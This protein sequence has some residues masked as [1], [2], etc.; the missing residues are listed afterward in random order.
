[1]LL[2]KTIEI[3]VT[4]KAIM[5]TTTKNVK[6]KIFLE[7][8]L[9][10]TFFAPWRLEAAVEMREY[11]VGDLFMT[12]FEGLRQSQH[13][14]R[15]RSAVVVLNADEVEDTYATI[16]PPQN[17]GTIIGNMA[18]FLDA[19]VMQAVLSRPLNVQWLE[20]FMGPKAM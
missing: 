9:H 20:Q 6:N 7:C 1:M 5:G 8:V 2:T 17:L 18:L 12:G 15:N 13:G 11:T 4:V 14:G 10:E 3:I 19:F 16:S